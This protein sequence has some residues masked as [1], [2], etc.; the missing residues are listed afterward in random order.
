MLSANIFYL[1][2][3]SNVIFNLNADEISKTMW[4]PL[5]HFIQPDVTNIYFKQ[6]NRRPLNVLVQKSIIMKKLENFAFKNF[7]FMKI[8]CMKIKEE[9]LFGLTFFMTMYIVRIMYK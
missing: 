1:K 5:K 8:C 3:Q 7:N 4:I 2:D 6:L 9:E